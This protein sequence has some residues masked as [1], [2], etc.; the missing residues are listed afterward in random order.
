MIY[1]CTFNP[2]VD[3][4]IQMDTIQFGS[5]NRIH[6]DYIEIG[7]KGI[8]VSRMLDSLSTPSVALGFLSGFTGD[9]IKQELSVKPH[10]T[11]QFLSV[12]GRSR[13][14]VKLTIN[15]SETEL[16]AKGPVILEEEFR[17]LLAQ[18]EQL[19]PEDLLIISGS[20]PN[21]ILN[22]YERI[23]Q[24]CSANA[25]PFVIDT[26]NHSL[27]ASLQYQPLLIKPN[28]QELLD[29]FDVKEATEEQ[30]IDYAKQLHQ[31]GAKRVIV[32]RGAK[33]SLYISESG[34]LTVSPPPGKVLNTT[35]AGDSM[36]AGY[37]HSYLKGE[38]EAA[39]LQ[40][41]TAAGSAT[42]FSLMIGTKDKIDTLLSKIEVRP[43]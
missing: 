7:G 15:G 24:L 40:M 22:A 1:T 13:I 18:I 37:I 3:Y 20:P 5:L 30:L 31:K 25:I 29:L 28:E 2:A 35:G 16:N 9:F 10:I 41:A 42:A 39:C 43:R 21:G 17:Q 6:S 11:P 33:P 8:Q 12:S 27:L 38:S 32:S 36:V 26:N 19:H 23:A 4:K 34:I 14:N